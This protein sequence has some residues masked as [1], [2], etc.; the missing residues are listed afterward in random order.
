MELL[1]FG[2]TAIM[3]LIYLALLVNFVYQPNNESRVRFGLIV[4]S[5][6][7]VMWIAT[8]D[9]PFRQ[10][11]F[12][13][14]WPF[15]LTQ[16][17]LVVVLALFDVPLMISKPTTALLF[18]IFVVAVGNQFFIAQLIGM[19]VYLI[20]SFGFIHSAWKKLSENQTLFQ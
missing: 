10:F 4:V 3:Y 14:E 12:G 7:L 8:G 19:T 11:L 9:I 13:P 17:A 2:L 5:V 1:P 20:L 6:L 16:M 15:M 18:V